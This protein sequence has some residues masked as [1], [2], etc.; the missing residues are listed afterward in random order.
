MEGIFHPGRPHEAFP[1]VGRSLIVSVVQAMRSFDRSA[2]LASHTRLALLWLWLCLWLRL[3][4]IH[5][6]GRLA[7]EV[8][9]QTKRQGSA[10]HRL[11]AC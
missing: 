1:L 8:T 9:R 3:L 4:P 10:F 11:G 7:G 5:S 2:T 6:K